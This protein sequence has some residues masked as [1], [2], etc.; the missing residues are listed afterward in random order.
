VTRLPSKVAG[1]HGSWHD[2]AEPAYWSQALQL[3]CCEPCIEAGAG[4]P[5]AFEQL[6][7]NVGA[8]QLL[9]AT[10]SQASCLRI[11]KF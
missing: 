3:L 9:Y 4:Q 8:L 10:A 7:L 5:M 1:L 6:F 2:I 11:G